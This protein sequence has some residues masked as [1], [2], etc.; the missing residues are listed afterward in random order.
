MKKIYSP[1]FSRLEVWDLHAIMIEVQ[2]RP[3]SE[4][5]ISSVSPQAERVR[6]TLWS[7]FNKDT[8]LIH[9][10]S[11][12]VR[13][14]PPSVPISEYYDIGVRIWTYEFWGKYAFSPLS[15]PLNDKA[16]LKS[17]RNFKN[18]RI[19]KGN[20]YPVKLETKKSKKNYSD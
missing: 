13:L 11:S 20:I 10:D 1:E 19:L 2:W 7:F 18:L 8:T 17:F 6:R 16:Y 4:M 15:R 14:L 9:E 5:Q 12:L 3:S